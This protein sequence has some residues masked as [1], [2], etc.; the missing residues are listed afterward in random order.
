MRRPRGSVGLRR[1]ASAWFAIAAV[2]L[3]MSLPAAAVQR[4]PPPEFDS[5]HVLPTL[6]Q[7]AAR[8]LMLQYLDVAVLAGA[9]LLAAWLVLR[10]R[11]RR[12]VVLLSLF[13]LLS[14][15]AYVAALRSES[16]S[17]RA[18]FWHGAAG[19]LLG[20]ASRAAFPKAL[21]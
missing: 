12:G 6:R 19:A 16:T 1:F 21:T 7:P 11:S 20:L 18:L 2:I 9:L 4:F 5:G 14:I 10:S 8:A 17:R 3:A 15:L 13:S